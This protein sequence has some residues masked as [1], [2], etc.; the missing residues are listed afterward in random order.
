[1]PVPFQVPIRLIDPNSVAQVPNSERFEAGPLMHSDAVE[2]TRRLRATDFLTCKDIPVVK[3]LA[4]G[5]EDES[6]QAREAA[7]ARNAQQQAAWEES[8]KQLYPDGQAAPVPQTSGAGS[9]AALAKK[10]DPVT[11]ARV[12]AGPP[13]LS[14]PSLS[15]AY[16]KPTKNNKPSMGAWGAKQQPVARQVWET[17]PPTVDGDDAALIWD[18]T[19]DSLPPPPQQGVWET[20]SNSSVGSETSGK[21]QRDLVAELAASMRTE[22]EAP[23]PVVNM[24]SSQGMDWQPHPVGPP[25]P[26]QHQQQQ[27]V[28]WQAQAVQA[29]QQ[30]MQFSAAMH[31]MQSQVHAS[32]AIVLFLT[33]DPILGPDLRQL[34]LGPSV[35]ARKRDAAARREPKPEQG[36][37]GPARAGPGQQLRARREL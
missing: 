26:G 12:P 31:R 2:L 15:E 23:D 29:Q 18:T 3:G 6:E 36:A 11:Q 16:R 32:P 10:S 5:H 34:H 21:Q 25:P 8:F 33:P 22:D 24:P 37:P 35:A 27:E 7:A 17:D 14:G 19:Q 20:Q 28:D 4:L 13:D 30:V 9:W 1:M